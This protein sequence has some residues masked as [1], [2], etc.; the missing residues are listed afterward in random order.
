MRKFILFCAYL[1]YGKSAV[2]VVQKRHRVSQVVLVPEKN[3]LVAV[4]DESHRSANLDCVPFG[5][6]TLLG[7]YIPVFKENK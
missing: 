7:L 6:F 1:R 3:Y 2:Q 5:Y 4:V